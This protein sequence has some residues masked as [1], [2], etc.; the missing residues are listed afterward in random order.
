MQQSLHFLHHG[1]DVARGGGQKFFEL[2]G[3]NFLG[4][5]HIRDHLDL[6]IVILRLPAQIHKAGP[7][8]F[9]QARLVEYPDAQRRLAGSVANQGLEK[10][11]ARARGSDLWI[12]QPI[13]AADL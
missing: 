7:H 6:S 3:G 10:R 5:N 11:L 13:D 9:S 1:V 4:A 8:G 12:H 2:F